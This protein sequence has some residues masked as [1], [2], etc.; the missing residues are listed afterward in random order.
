M[1]SDPP[2]IHIDS[3][4]RMAAGNGQN[5]SASIGR[6]GAQLGMTKIGCTVV[7]LQPGERAWPYHLHYGQ[8]ELFFVLEGEG[9]LRYDDEEYK[10]RQ[11][12]FF[13]AGTGPGTAHQIVNSSDA[14]LRYFALSSTDDP[15]VCYYPDSKK[16]GA[17][18]WRDDGKGVRFLAHDDAGVDYFDGEQ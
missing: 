9:T 16:Y 11:G 5:F 7:D 8:E 4:E 2:K 15:E 1:A 12:E 3:I 14:K 18:C 6:V 13:F 17:Y 10:L